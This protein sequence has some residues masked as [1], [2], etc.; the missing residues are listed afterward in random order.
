MSRIHELK[1][2]VST[3]ERPELPNYDSHDFEHIA[4]ILKQLRFGL[5]E[6]M[7]DIFSPALSLQLDRLVQQEEAVCLEKQEDNR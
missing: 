3:V 5:E 1:T 4:D 6:R 2:S 7:T